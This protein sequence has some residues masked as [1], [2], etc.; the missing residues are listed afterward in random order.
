MAAKAFSTPAPAIPPALQLTHKADAYIACALRPIGCPPGLDPVRWRKALAKRIERHQAAADALIAALDAMDGDAD[1][2]PS[3]GAPE[4]ILPS[5]W[6]FGCL[7]DRNCSQVHW[8]DGAPGDNEGEI[9]DGHGGDILDEPHDA[10]LDLR[11]ADGLELGEGDDSYYDSGQM[12]R[13]GN[14]AVWSETP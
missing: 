14:E 10:E 3:L 4:I 11:E 13:G 12:I 2:E 8:A 5:G 9:E 7:I 6:G 1:L